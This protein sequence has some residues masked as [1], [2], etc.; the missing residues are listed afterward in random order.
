MTRDI[1]IQNTVGLLTLVKGHDVNTVGLLTLVKGHDA[2]TVGLLNLVKGH[3][4]ALQMSADLL[5]I[6]VCLIDVYQ[7][8]Y[9]LAK[10]A[11]SIVIVTLRSISSAKTLQRCS[12][13]AKL[14]HERHILDVHRRHI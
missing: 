12:N 3:D 8:I 10:I 6:H 5:V 1:S 11:S 2:N 9:T 14:K 7:D 4:V 13:T